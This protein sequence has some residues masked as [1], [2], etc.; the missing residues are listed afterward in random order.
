MSAETYR[1]DQVP[2]GTQVTLLKPKAIIRCSTAT[3]L[4]EL[5]QYSS[6]RDLAWCEVDGTLVATFDEARASRDERTVGRL[7]EI[8]S[9]AFTARSCSTAWK[10]PLFD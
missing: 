9:R 1:I 5:R 2:G 3:L 7:T 6:V 10:S 8:V 4:D